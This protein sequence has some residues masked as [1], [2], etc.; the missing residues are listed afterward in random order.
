MQRAR[1]WW[2]QGEMLALVW[3]EKEGKEHPLVVPLGDP[4][5]KGAWFKYYFHYFLF[6][7]FYVGSDVMPPWLW[8]WKQDVLLQGSRFV[9]LTRVPQR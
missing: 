5:Q 6:L 3:T 9:I 2:A 1:W 7:Y 4:W 8:A